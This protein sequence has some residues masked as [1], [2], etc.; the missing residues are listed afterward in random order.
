MRLFRIHDQGEPVRDIQDRL[1]ALGFFPANR[2]RPGVFG[3]ATQRAVVTFQD[4]KGLAPDGIVGPQTWNALVAAGHRL[5]DRLLYHKIPMMRGDD[6]AELQRRL[7]SLGFDAK[8]V[9]GIF[10]PDTLHAVLEFQQNRGLPEDGIA[11]PGLAAELDLI[12]RA[13]QKHGREAVRERQWILGLPPTVAGQ[14]VFIDAFCRTDEEDQACWEAATRA[15]RLL[16]EL[17]AAAELSRSADTRPNDRIRAQR[18]NR[19]GIDFVLSF[20]LPLADVP[21]V[22]YFASEYS[23]S[24]AGEALATAIARKL[25]TGPVGRATP[26]LKETR[27]PAV[28]VAIAEPVG[29]EQVVAGIVDLFATASDGLILRT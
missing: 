22:Y 26:M 15:A 4:S 11:G 25:G 8:K 6:V 29:V 12:D 2:D 13:T 7:N 14:R 17:G 19:R 16:Q 21:G 27:D 18:A 1:F 23:S 28:I 24:A 9:D 5:G 10:G 20:S 3:E